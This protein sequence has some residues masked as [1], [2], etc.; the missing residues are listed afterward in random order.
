MRSDSNSVVLRVNI[1]E[2]AD[3]FDVQSI[4]A[5]DKQVI[6]ATSVL[7][8]IFK[9]HGLDKSNILKQACNRVSDILYT[10]LTGEQ[11]VDKN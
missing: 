1:N 8:D 11:N 9:R 4:G 2:E 3:I 10:S 5:L 6:A 7:A